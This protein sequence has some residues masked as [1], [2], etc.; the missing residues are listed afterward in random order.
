MAEA[1]E[2]Q[3]EEHKLQTDTNSTIWGSFHRNH[4]AYANNTQHIHT[5]FST[6]LEYGRRWDFRCLGLRGVTCRAGFM[7]EW[8]VQLHWALYSGFSALWSPSQI[9]NNFIFEFEFC[10][11]SLMRQ[12]SMNQGLGASVHSW[13]C[14]LGTG[15]LLPAHR[16]HP[17]TA[18]ALAGVWVQ[19]QE[20]QGW[21]HPIHQRSNAQI[22]IIRNSLL[23]V[24]AIC[25]VGQ[26]DSMVPS[27]TVLCWAATGHHLSPFL[28]KSSWKEAKAGRLSSRVK[29]KIWGYINI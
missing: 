4:D 8:L 26:R 3:R 7:D 10:K 12:Q 19:V 28:L 22:S 20:D 6:N 17:M 1:I 5:G 16:S 13:S 21:V 9:L 25:Y 29:N 2:R 15:S 11:W 24:K 27:S 18:T 14:L 23:W